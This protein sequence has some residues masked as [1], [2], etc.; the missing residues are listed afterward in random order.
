MKLLRTRFEE[1]VSA[2]IDGDADVEKTKKALI[3]RL[4][5]AVRADTL[6]RAI[7]EQAEKFKPW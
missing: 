4:I 7:R 1:I 5:S 6:A 3:D 2:W